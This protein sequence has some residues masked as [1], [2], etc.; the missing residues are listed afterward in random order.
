MFERHRYVTVLALL[1]LV[2][3]GIWPFYGLR[4]EILG[5]FLVFLI[6][7]IAY[8]LFGSQAKNE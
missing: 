3:V 5:A 4:I 1:G 7:Q 6:I 2:Q 8:W